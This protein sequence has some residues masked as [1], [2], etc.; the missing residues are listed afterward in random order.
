MIWQ[1]FTT[2]P[3]TLDDEPP[4]LEDSLSDEDDSSAVPSKIPS[5]VHVP[6]SH[7]PKRKRK[8]K[9]KVATEATPDTIRAVWLRSHPSIHDEVFSSLHTAI[10][11]TLEAEKRASSTQVEV[12]M[13]DLRGQTNVFE[14]MGPKASQVLK[15]ALNPTPQDQREDF[16]KVTIP[17][18]VV[19][20]LTYMEL[21]VLVI[22]N[23]LA[24]FWV[25][26]P[27]NDH[28]VQGY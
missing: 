9:A 14:I 4:E 13:V 7:P 26:S 5:K 16:R 12:E 15:G 17:L 27:W 22:I 2:T 10:S 11:L 8:G 24:N 25:S 23:A 19:F 1:P 6:L 21:L 18:P 28:R 20:S 3:L